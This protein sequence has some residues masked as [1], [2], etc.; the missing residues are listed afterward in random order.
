MTPT[1]VCFV[2]NTGVQMLH[3][4]SLEESHERTTNA[5]ETTEETGEFNWVFDIELLA[6][7]TPL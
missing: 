1:F 7:E 2:E 4:K 6:E 3:V 5:S